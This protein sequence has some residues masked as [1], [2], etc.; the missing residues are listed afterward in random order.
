LPEELE[1]LLGGYERG[2][3]INELADQFAI[4]RSTVLDHLNRSFARR[5]YPVLDDKGVEV[6]KRLYGSGLS[7]RDVGTALEVHASTV[8]SA[9]LNAGVQMRDRHR[10]SRA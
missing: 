6:A 2:A 10:R 4:H 7:L 8:R 9:L 3:P 1:A 5:R